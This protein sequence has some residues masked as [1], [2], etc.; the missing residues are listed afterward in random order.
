M[1]GFNLFDNL[2]PLWPHTWYSFLISHFH[3]FEIFL[4]ILFSSLFWTA[5]SSSFI[6]APFQYNHSLPLRIHSSKMTLSNQSLCFCKS[7]YV[8]SYLKKYSRKLCHSENTNSEA[9]KAWRA[10]KILPVIKI[11]EKLFERI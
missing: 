7:D 6:W 11:I 8:S 3:D 1:M 4:H 9:R 2:P 10:T 5:L